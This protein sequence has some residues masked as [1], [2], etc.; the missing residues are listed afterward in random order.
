MLTTIALSFL[1]G[2]PA[3]ATPAQEPMPTPSASESPEQ[4]AKTELKPL[5]FRVLGGNVAGTERGLEGRTESWAKFDRVLGDTFLRMRYHQFK[6]DGSLNYS[7]V[8]LFLPLADNKIEAWFFDEMGETSSWSGTISDRGMQLTTSSADGTIVGEQV[9]EWTNGGYQFR[10]MG[11]GP[12]GAEGGLIEYL[13]GEYEPTSKWR[14]LPA[15]ANLEKSARALPFGWYLGSF[16]GK[17]ISIYG[18]SEGVMSTTLGPGPWFYT[19]Y[20]SA[21]KGEVVFSGLGFVSASKN[22]DYTLHWF[23]QGGAHSI[24]EGKVLADGNTNAVVRNEDG[25]VI[26]RHTDTRTGEDSYTFSIKQL[27]ETSGEWKLFM[28][29]NYLRQP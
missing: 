23:E 11:F 17:E 29:G 25:E 13:S 20:N 12:A 10:L 18:A 6:A 22:G 9:Y 21:V 8:Q 14:S 24:I 28:T 4:A 19:E 16:R 26:E 5:L 7:M 27:D 15:N 1:V 2:A 3:S